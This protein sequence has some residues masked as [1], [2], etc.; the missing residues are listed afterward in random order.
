MKKITAI[1]FGR[2]DPGR[3]SCCGDDPH[4]L[5]GTALELIRDALD[6]DG[7]TELPT[8]HLRLAKRARNE[9]HRERAAEKCAPLLRRDKAPGSR[10]DEM[11]HPAAVSTRTGNASRQQGRTSRPR[12]AAGKFRRHVSPFGFS[13]VVVRQELLH[14]AR[15]YHQQ[16][17]WGRDGGP[18]EFMLILASLFD[19]VMG[20]RGYSVS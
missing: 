17:L 14:R 9:S 12:M 19:D 6:R 11:A 3:P 4:H 20:S 8:T 7:V 2:P 18:D 16:F 1:V 10:R 13:G 5:V 15:A